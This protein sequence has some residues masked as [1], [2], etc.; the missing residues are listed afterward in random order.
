MNSIH[1]TQRYIKKKPFQA[2]I[3]I[4]KKQSINY[5]AFIRVQKN[6]VIPPVEAQGVERRGTECKQRRD[7]ETQTEMRRGLK[8]IRNQG[9]DKY[10]AEVLEGR[11]VEGVAQ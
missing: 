7:G 1:V 8:E 3:S 6:H 10:K 9:G 2:V 11:T 4:L 5:L